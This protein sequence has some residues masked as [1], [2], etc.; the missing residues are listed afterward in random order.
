MAFL[1]KAVFDA[2]HA[3]MQALMAEQGLDGLVFTQAD[4]LQ[5]ASNFNLDVQTWERPVALVVPK[6]GAPFALLNELSTHHWRMAEERGQLW[7][8]EA[9]FYDEHIGRS[10]AK[11]LVTAWSEILAAA[12]RRRGLTAGRLGADT[13]TA[14]L[15]GVSDQL[16]ELA[17]EARTAELRVLRWCKQPEELELMRAAAALS[18]WAQER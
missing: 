7:V 18:D 17:I 5:F 10:N 1:S 16:P 3:A 6:E 13:L 8:E 15:A 11:R 12:L 2:R 4:F 9:A 14:P